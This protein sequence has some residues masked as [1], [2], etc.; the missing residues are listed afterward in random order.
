MSIDVTS[1]SM[2]DDI[3][4]RLA[5]SDRYNA[6]LDAVNDD[7]IRSQ[8]DATV[9]AFVLE[10]TSGFGMLSGTLGDPAA[11]DELIRLAKARGR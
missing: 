9:K 7:A 8:V 1:G 5:L 6:I 2:G 4:S 10:L 11:R 3:L